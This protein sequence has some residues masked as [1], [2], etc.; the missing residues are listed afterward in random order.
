MSWS[1]PLGRMIAWALIAVVVAVLYLPMVPPALFSLNEAGPAA[2]LRQPTLHW[3]SEIWANAVLVG[4]MWTSLAAALIVGLVAPVLG[5]LAALAVRELKMPRLVLLVIGDRA[6]PAC[7]HDG[8]GE[9][10]HH[11]QTADELPHLL[12]PP[13]VRVGSTRNQ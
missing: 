13:T 1:S 4:A 10:Q 11:H 7:E 6:L 3:Y 9:N 12:D 5:L 2:A 8:A